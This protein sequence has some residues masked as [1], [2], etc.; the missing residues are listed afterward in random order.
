MKITH[1]PD[2]RPLRAAAYPPAGDQLDAIWKI[3]NGL[4]AGEDP[5][6]DALAVRDAVLAVK[7]KFPKG[8]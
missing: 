2:P 4:I 1:N 6:A 7:A 5:D 3:V 8:R